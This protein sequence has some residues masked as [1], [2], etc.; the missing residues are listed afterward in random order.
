MRLTAT[1][2]YTLLRPTRC[3]LRVYLVDRHEEP[4]AA[5]GAFEQLLF[6]LGARHE[7]AHLRTLPNHLDL[8]GL[9]DPTRVE[10]T[11]GSR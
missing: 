3:D 9:G 6:R 11:R 7:A 1:D 2:L 10:A 5:P 4:T 8:R